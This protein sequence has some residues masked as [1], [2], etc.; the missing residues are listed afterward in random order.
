M[1]LKLLLILL[2][3]P[4]LTLW[5][6]IWLKLVH[7]FLLPYLN[8]LIM[9]VA[10]SPLALYRQFFLDFSMA[11][12]SIKTYSLKP[13]LQSHFAIIFWDR[14]CWKEFGILLTLF[15][16]VTKSDAG[17]VSKFDFYLSNLCSLL[18]LATEKWRI[19]LFLTW[20][21]PKIFFYI[22]IFYSRSFGYIALS[23]FESLVSYE[24]VLYF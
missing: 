8:C 23:N 4:P 12:G 1:K 7:V 9:V 10:C 24:K 14:V 3:R 13:G 17:A 20:F 22:S 5:V 15:G 6:Y 21:A 19:L 16:C 18:S 11:S 2:F